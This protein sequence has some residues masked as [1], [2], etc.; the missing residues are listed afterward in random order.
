MN[1]LRHLKEED[2]RVS[3]RFCGDSGTISLYVVSAKNRSAERVEN[4]TYSAVNGSGANSLWAAAPL[5]CW[6]RAKSWISVTPA[7]FAAQPN[8]NPIRH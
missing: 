2:E 1:S 5:K 3:H 7:Y 6:N 4:I 8:L